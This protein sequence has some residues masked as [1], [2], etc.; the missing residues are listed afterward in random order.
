MNRFVVLAA[1]VG[2][3]LSLIAPGA[4][5]FKP[6]THSNTGSRPAP[7]HRRRQRHDR[8]PRLPG[9]PGRWR[10]AAG[11]AVVLQRRCHRSGRLPRPDDGAVD[12]PPGRHRQ[13]A[14][15]I[16]AKAWAA[17]SDPSYSAAEKSQILAFAY[18]FLTHAAGDMWAHTLVNELS[19]EVFPAVE[20][21][22]DEPGCCV[23]R[24]PA[25]HRRGVHR[26]R[27]PGLRRE[28]DR[29]TLADGDVSDDSTPGIAFDSP[30]R[31]IHET[32]VAQNADAPSE[33]AR[34]ADRLLHRP[35]V[36]PRGLRLTPARSRC[37]PPWTSSARAR[38]TTE[39][40]RACDFDA[41]TSST[42]RPPCWS[43]ASTVSSIGGSAARVRHEHAGS[44]AKVVL[45]AYV[46]AWIADIDD[47]LAHW[48][49]LGLA[50]TRA[51]FDPQ[52]RRD[53]QNDECGSVGQRDQRVRCNCED[54]IGAG[55]HPAARG[56]PL[57]QPP[58]AVD[59][60]R[61]GLRRRGARRL[62]DAWT[63]STCRRPRP[64]PDREALAEIKDS[65][66]DQV[67]HSCR[68]RSGSTS[69]SSTPSSRPDQLA[70]RRSPASTLPVVG[71]QTV[72][73][74]A[75]GRTPRSTDICVCPPA[76]TTGSR[77]G[78]SSQTTTSSPKTFA[79]VKNAVTTAKLPPLDAGP[80]EQ[81][82]DDMLVASGDIKT[83]AR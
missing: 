42:A 65:A 15:Y 31:F 50:S 24:H 4:Q 2:A 14:Q 83:G 77:S 29:T 20:R 7:T 73:L 51:L 54:G 27:H 16:L 70:E 33:R 19:G 75:P 9:R 22:A 18:G 30:N 58:P 6:Y 71:T 61:A 43:W 13:V 55:R 82:T 36:L 66:A 41:R 34:P 39:Q 68:T 59:A 56:G 79:A 28:P 57:H 3:A 53:T 32:L 76:T 48:G 26:R 38:S 25:H 69:I 80:A 10:G 40:R 11:L 12:H 1:T 35:A 64:Q 67:K 37:R 46:N 5:A 52:A 44:P 74:F 17:Q 47:G 45:D 23:D 62:Q 8:R 81:R 63:R 60:R 21:R 78:G 72:H 49:E